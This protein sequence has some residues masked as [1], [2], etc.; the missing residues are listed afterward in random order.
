MT[1]CPYATWVKI[2]IF[3]TKMAI[4]THMKYDQVVS[5]KVNMEGYQS[6][7][8]KLVHWSKIELYLSIGLCILA[9]NKFACFWDTHLQK[10]I[11]EL[12]ILNSE[13]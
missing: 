8:D 1:T 4:L 11:I 3:F 9:I 7:S 2:T 5:N 6:H 12:Q 13:K 10:K